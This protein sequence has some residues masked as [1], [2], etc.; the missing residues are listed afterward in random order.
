M[1]LP[2]VTNTWQAWYYNNT[3]YHRIGGPAWLDNTVKDQIR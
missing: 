3:Q 1:K 2:I